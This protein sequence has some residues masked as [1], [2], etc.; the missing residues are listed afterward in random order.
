MFL[1]I[2]SLC[3]SCSVFSCLYSAFCFYV[4][5]FLLLKLSAVYG[6]CSKYLL[7]SCCFVLFFLILWGKTLL[8][9]TNVQVNLIQL[10]ISLIANS[11]KKQQ[12][13]SDFQRAVQITVRIAKPFVLWVEYSKVWFRECVGK[14]RAVGVMYAGCSVAAVN[15]YVHTILILDL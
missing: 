11:V 7:R 3:H 8:L 15:T 6:M 9:S 13:S 10:S 2:H 4:C 5:L 12:T 1:N 14:G